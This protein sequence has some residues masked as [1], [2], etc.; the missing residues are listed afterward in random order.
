MS[1]PDDS[2]AAK[3]FQIIVS[4]SG[5]GPTVNDDLDKDVSASNSDTNSIDDD[6]DCVENNYTKPTPIYVSASNQLPLLTINELFYWSASNRKC[7]I[8]LQ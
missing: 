7:T 3:D 2:E 6:V 4:A 5:D 1:E 8:C